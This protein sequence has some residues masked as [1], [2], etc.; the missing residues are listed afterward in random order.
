MGTSHSPASKIQREAPQ[1]VPVGGK[2]STLTPSRL[3]P[4][5]TRLLVPTLLCR[6]Q[7]QEM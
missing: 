3:P 1:S 5:P 6:T 7:E 2:L 4:H